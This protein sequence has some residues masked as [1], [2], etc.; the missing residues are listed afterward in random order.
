[1]K[2]PGELWA[3]RMKILDCESIDSTFASIEE[4]LRIER[5][6][7]EEVLGDLDLE[8]EC[9]RAGGRSAGEILLDTAS[10]HARA[11]AT[12]F[13]RTC[14]FHFTRTHPPNIFSRGLLPLND[15]LPF[16]WGFLLMLLPEDFPL[17]EWYGF[18]QNPPSG[19]Y[20]ARLADSA[21]LGPFAL[22]TREA[23][24]SGCPAGIHDSLRAPEIVEEICAAFGAE[25]DF[26]LLGAY[27][28]NTKPCVVSFMDSETRPEYLGAA[29]HYLYRHL[30]G[31]PQPA[32]SGTRFNSKGV[33]IPQENIRKVEFLPV[34]TP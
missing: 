3:T 31:E 19:P 32:D 16:L 7:L 22:L 29:L 26:D 23:G 9:R 18:A 14:W 4:I 1:M 15:A 8:E 13:D 25:H 34:D 28:R 24:L 17:R 2:Y 10:R 33:A 11:E 27:R 5:S 21:L 12:A 6:L 20:H 30:R